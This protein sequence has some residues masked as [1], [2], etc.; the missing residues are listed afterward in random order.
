[1]LRL[2]SVRRSYVPVQF[3]RPPDPTHLCFAEWII[4]RCIAYDQPTF[5]IVVAVVLVE[6][7]Q[8]EIGDNADLRVGWCARPV[9]EQTALVVVQRKDR[10]VGVTLCAVDLDKMPKKLLQA[11]QPIGLAHLSVGRDSGVHHVC[12]PGVWWCWFNTPTTHPQ[13]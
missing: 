3:I 7:I 2:R 12:S 9:H 6:A 1:M 13:M 4:G 11:L 10:H 8:P 5:H